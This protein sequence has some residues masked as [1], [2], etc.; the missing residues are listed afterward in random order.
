MRRPEFIARQGRCPSG[1]LGRLIGSIMATETAGAND[2]V[3]AA[4][5]LQPTDRVL[6]IGFGHGRTLE[7]VGRQLTAGFAAGVD[8]SE[9][10]VRMTARRCRDLITAG[11]VT[12]HQGDST[13][14]PFP[15]GHFNKAYSVHTL[16]FWSHPEEHLREIHRVLCS[17]GPLA[18]GFRTAEDPGARDFPETVYRFYSQAEV[19]M[20]LQAAGFGEVILSES[21]LHCGFVIASAT[22]S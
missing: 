5:A 21:A 4:L 22:R 3:L 18:L 10:M 2:A 1:L 20:L 9:T 15:T 12:V 7:R 8:L 11:R 19:T 16:Y 13:R 17:G 6:E 14:L